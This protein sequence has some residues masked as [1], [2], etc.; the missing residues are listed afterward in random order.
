[1][2]GLTSSSGRFQQFNV[3][4]ISS[5]RFIAFGIQ[6]I[7]RHILVGDVRPSTGLSYRAA[8]PFSYPLWPLE[9]LRAVRAIRRRMSRR[10]NRTGWYRRRRR[11]VKR[12]FLTQDPN[13]PSRCPPASNPSPAVLATGAFL[14]MVWRPGRRARVRAASISRSG[15]TRTR[16]RLSETN[17]LLI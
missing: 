7:Q 13:P 17:A 6:K 4:T 8:R 12:D 3:S 14:R 11:G 16:L 5:R 9:E 1:M 15:S 10:R 2:A